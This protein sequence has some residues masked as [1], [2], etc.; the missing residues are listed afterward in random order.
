M[1]MPQVGKRYRLNIRLNKE[2]Q[3]RCC[4]RVLGLTI[5]KYPEIQGRVVTVYQTHPF[6][7]DCRW[8]SKSYEAKEGEFVIG[9][10]EWGY[11]AV[12]YTWLEP[13]EEGD[14]PCND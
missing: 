14:A 5:T 1:E 8:C 6:I 4:N 2:Y 13:L 7:V 10:Q 9:L 11:V 3:T 12:P